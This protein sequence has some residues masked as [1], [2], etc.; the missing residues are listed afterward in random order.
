MT[1]ATAF[2]KPAEEPARSYLRFQVTAVG[3]GMNPPW[4]QGHNFRKPPGE[5]TD[6]VL[7]R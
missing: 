7:R 6:Q 1:A 4:I 3:A 2:S 5:P